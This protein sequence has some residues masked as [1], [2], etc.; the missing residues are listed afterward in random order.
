MVTKPD[1]QT[2]CQYEITASKLKIICSLFEELDLRLSKRYNAVYGHRDV[3]HV[4]TKAGYANSSIAAAVASLCQTAPPTVSGT[5]SDGDTHKTPRVPT[6]DFVLSALGHVKPEDAA[7]WGDRG[8]R[9]TVRHARRCGMLQGVDT[10]A[11]DVTDIRYYGKGLE[12]YTR[13]TYPSNG[14]STAISHITFHGIGGTAN[15][16]LAS[17]LFPRNC[18]L[19]DFVTKL[20][21]AAARSGVPV[22]HLLLD[23]GF[24]SVDCMLA[25]G[26][27]GRT[28]IMPA[29]KNSRIRDLIIEYHEG[30]RTQVSEYTMVNKEGRSVTF[31]LLIVKKSKKGGG[32]KGRKKKKEKDDDDVT[33]QYVVFATNRRIRSVRA[34]IDSI[35]EEY[36]TR[37]EI[38]TGF[39]VIKGAMGWT[40]SNS[41]TVRLLLFYLPL[42]MY[43]MWRITRFVDKG[44]DWGGWAGGDRFTMNLFM[45]CV[46]DITGSFVPD[47]GK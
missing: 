34:T 43:N 7:A 3:L 13:K 29:V 30:R 18:K 39:R 5:G 46:V 23:R 38:E 15:I 42:L 8:L 11:I 6:A 40:C 25:A 26:L 24:F 31:T 20:L 17:K 16:V 14:T 2:T 1:D 47:R 45:G 22:R 21:A 28:Y 44:V 37:W 32:K 19:A 9:C 10:Y 36:R 35:P 4:L 41:P 27:M 33:S 12:D